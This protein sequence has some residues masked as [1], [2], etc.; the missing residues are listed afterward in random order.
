L[1]YRTSIIAAH[2]YLLKS[3]APEGILAG[4]K[5][6]SVLDGLDITIN[7]QEV[8]FDGANFG[9]SGVVTACA[10]VLGAAAN[11]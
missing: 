5:M 1:S 10:D 4:R 9:T 3:K 7:G 11:I 8:M 2:K 6:L